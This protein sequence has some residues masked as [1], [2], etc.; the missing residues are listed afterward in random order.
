MT[1]LSDE[2]RMFTDEMSDEAR[3]LMDIRA[4]MISI[5]DTLWRFGQTFDYWAPKFFS[6]LK[7]SLGVD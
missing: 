2:A 3:M 5:D 7:Y 1:E 6:L 4:Q